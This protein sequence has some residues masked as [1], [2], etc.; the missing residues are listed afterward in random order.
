MGSTNTLLILQ[1]PNQQSAQSR[2]SQSP[3]LGRPSPRHGIID[4]DGGSA[5]ISQTVQAGDALAAAE[6]R[7]VRGICCAAVGV[8]GA[9]GCAGVCF[10]VCCCVVAGGEA[11]CEVEG[12]EGAG[13]IPYLHTCQI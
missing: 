2:P 5:R 9:G 12:L 1:Q 6:G 11:A 3:Q 4:C 13:W 10:C 8:V 7:G